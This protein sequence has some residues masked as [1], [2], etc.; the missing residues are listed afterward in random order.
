MKQNWRKSLQVL[1]VAAGDSFLPGTQ[2]IFLGLS[3]SLRSQKSKL[4]VSQEGRNE[5]GVKLL[6]HDSFETTAEAARKQAA[7]R[8]CLKDTNQTEDYF[9][10]FHSIG[11][12]G[13]CVGSRFADRMI[14]PGSIEYR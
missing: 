8:E 11:I 7:S 10:K 5:I 2:K 1:D 3:K 14:H 12:P 4:K 6:K 9:S 13:N